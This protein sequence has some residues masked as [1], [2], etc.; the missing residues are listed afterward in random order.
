[1]QKLFKD[2]NIKLAVIGFILFVELSMFISFKRDL[3]TN[4]NS[5]NSVITSFQTVIREKANNS[6]NNAQNEIALSNEDSEEINEQPDIAQVS[7]TPVEVIPIVEQDV[8]GTVTN[9]EL[10][11]QIVTYAKQF[12]GNPYV[13]GGTSLT[14]GIDCSGFVQ[15][16]FSNFGI[17]LP[18]SA[19]E[20]GN[21]GNYVSIEN[22]QI[23]DVILYGY[24][25]SIGHAAIYIGDG[26]IIHA[27]NPEHGI[28]ISNYQFM[29][30]I[31]I[32]RVL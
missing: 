3:R 8:V 26:L 6:W 22:I 19:P 15:A 27:M 1:M 21:I 12:N 23:G 28:T 9:L 10:A 11:N 4:N 31:T 2:N 29:P 30:I 13:Y 16:I 14:N 25:G 7:A 24:D 18:R 20:Q 17:S 32:R 5:N